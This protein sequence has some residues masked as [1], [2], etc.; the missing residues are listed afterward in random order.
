[1]ITTLQFL[2]FNCNF[3][4]K[5]AQIDKKY[6]LL[7]DVNWCF[8]FNSKILLLTILIC[9]DIFIKYKASIWNEN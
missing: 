2:N 6:F 7:H 5:K 3:N 1:M 4:F 9:I 8:I